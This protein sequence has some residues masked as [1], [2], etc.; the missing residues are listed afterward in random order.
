M[1]HFK[2]EKGAC[3]GGL[4]SLYLFVTA[5]EVPFVLMK[6]RELIKGFSIFCRHVLFIESGDISTFLS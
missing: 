2:L 1:Q 6:G 4:I 5:F 3:Q